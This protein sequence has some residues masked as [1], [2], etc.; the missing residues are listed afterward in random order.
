MITIR[1][2]SPDDQIGVRALH[3]RT[4]P[5][6]TKQDSGP[7]PWPADLDRISENYLAFWIATANRLEG[8]QIVGMVG[9]VAPGP[10]VPE[11]VRRGREDLVRLQRMRIAPEYQRQ[12]IGARLVETVV[13]WARERDTAEIILET[14]VQ[15]D[16]AVALYRHKGFTEIARS[17]MGPYELIWF[18]LPL[19]PNLW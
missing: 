4:P 3:D 11:A 8:E 9:V 14:T 18:T 17:M 16:A 13:A 6:G 5:A 10:D 19:A 7:Q 2:W 15:Q 12:G 1:S